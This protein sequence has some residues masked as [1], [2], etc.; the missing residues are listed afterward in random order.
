MLCIF[1]VAETN[2][3]ITVLKGLYYNDSIIGV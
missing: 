1:S 3:Q 2:R